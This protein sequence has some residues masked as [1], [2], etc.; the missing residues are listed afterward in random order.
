MRSRSALALSLTLAAVLAGCSSTPTVPSGIV[1][2]VIT[3]KV[4]PNPVPIT[5]STTSI[6]L[7]SVKYKVVVTES[8]GL[9]GEFVLIN[10]TIFDYAS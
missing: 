8:A 3:V 9:G 4:D 2:S 5:N 7:H 10:S 1:R 6:G